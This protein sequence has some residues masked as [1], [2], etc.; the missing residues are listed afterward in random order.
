MPRAWHAPNVAIGS[1]SGLAKQ[2]ELYAWADVIVVPLRPNF[3]ASGITVMLEAAALGK[4][5]IVSDVGGLTDYFPHDTA[6]Y[7]P[8]FDDPRIIAGQATI[9]VEILEALPDAGT[10]IVPLSGGGLFSG[11]AFA[12]KAIRPSIAV[13]GVSMARGAAM[14]ASLA[15]GRPVDVEEQPTLADSLGG[16]IGLDNRY[17]F[18]LTRA[19]ADDVVLLD[20]RSIARGIA[21]AYREERLVVEGAGAVGIAALLDE[22]VPRSRRDGPIVV[23]VS[24]ANIDMAAHRRLIAEN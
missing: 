5:M 18:D 9:G 20:E 1:A 21:H 17:T 11:V 15:A 13:I 22:A 16:G 19:L 12:A 6:A 7:V 14:H 8:P 4:P 23:V 2:H 24:G 3:H 10:L